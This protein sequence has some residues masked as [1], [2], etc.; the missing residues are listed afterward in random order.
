MHLTDELVTER[1]PDPCVG[2]HAVAK[3]QIRH[4]PQLM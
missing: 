4:R 3:V 2:H 1:H